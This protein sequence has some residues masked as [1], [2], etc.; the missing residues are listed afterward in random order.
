M[1]TIGKKVVAFLCAVLV[2]M[3]SMAEP[4]LFRHVEAADTEGT[5]EVVTFADFGVK[6]DTYGIKMGSNGTDVSLTTSGTCGKNSLDGVLFHGKVKFSTEA[7]IT[8]SVFGTDNAW[9]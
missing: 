2:V 8:I 5:T 3:A 1:K 7:P 4:F 9:K 6:D